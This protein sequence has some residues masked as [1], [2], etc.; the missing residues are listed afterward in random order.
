MANPIQA[1]TF[2]SNGELITRQATPELSA[3][4]YCVYVRINETTAVYKC[5]ATA[6]EASLQEGEYRELSSLPPN[7]IEYTL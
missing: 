4:P 3:F 7:S 2:N 1:P 5:Y 6:A